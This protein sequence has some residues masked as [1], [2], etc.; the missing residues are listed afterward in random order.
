MVGMKQ[1]PTAE[2]APLDLQPASSPS[3]ARRRVFYLVDSLDVGGTETQAVELALRMPVSRYDVT[4]GCLRA[5]GPL[6]ERVEGSSVVVEEFY[7]KGGLDS[8]AGVWQLLR[9]AAFLRR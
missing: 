2:A 8:P 4:L 3:R 5:Q 6:L 1:T 9:M 7:P